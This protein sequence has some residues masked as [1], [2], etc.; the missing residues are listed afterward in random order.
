MVLVCSR[1]LPILK[2]EGILY[3]LGYFVLLPVAKLKII[4]SSGGNK[5]D[6]VL[7]LGKEKK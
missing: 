2:L 5:G 3:G 4:Y 6:F 1:L 7:K